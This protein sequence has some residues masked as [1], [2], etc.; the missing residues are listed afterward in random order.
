MT[1]GDPDSQGETLLPGHWPRGGDVEGS[2]SDFKLP[3]H[4]LHYLPRFF[5]GFRACRGTVTAT[6]E[7]NLLQHLAAVREEFLYVNFLDPHKS[8]DALERSR[9]REILDGYSVVPQSTR[10]L[11]TYWRR[12]TMVA[13]AGGYCRTAFQGARGVTQGY[14]LSPTIFN[15]LMDVLV[16]NWVTVVIVGA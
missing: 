3:A 13:R 16:R 8:H 10:L 2:G 4:G 6:L 7:A 9:C 1:G 14:M 5:R 12:I 15:V 11:Q